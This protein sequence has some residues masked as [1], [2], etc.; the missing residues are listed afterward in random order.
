MERRAVFDGLAERPV[1]RFAA[2][3]AHGIERNDLPVD[4]GAGRDPV[5][6]E[7]FSIIGILDIADEWACESRFG[8]FPLEFADQT[9]I[10]FLR[11]FVRSRFENLFDAVPVAEPEAIPSSTDTDDAANVLIAVVKGVGVDLDTG[12][13]G[14]SG[15]LDCVNI[16]LL[17]AW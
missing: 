15:F 17:R 1:S 5:F 6:I 11:V 12:C 8:R 7:T 2:P 10:D 9:A 16:V 13:T 3:F 14:S 4:A